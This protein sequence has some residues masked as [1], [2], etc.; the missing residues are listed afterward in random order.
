MRPSD[1]LFFALFVSFRGHCFGV[2]LIAAWP[3]KV[4]RG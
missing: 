1:G 3:R 4:M 2:D